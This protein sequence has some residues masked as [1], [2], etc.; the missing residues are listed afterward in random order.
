MV[1]ALGDGNLGKKGARR[2]SLP[3]REK[4]AG[5]SLTFGFECQRGPYESCLFLLIYLEKTRVYKKVAPFLSFLSPPGHVT[6]FPSV[7]LGRGEEEK[8]VFAI[9]ADDDADKRNE[10]GWAAIFCRL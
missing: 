6:S 4:D 1:I 5:C 10:G 3:D 8:V 9:R 2:G 7:R